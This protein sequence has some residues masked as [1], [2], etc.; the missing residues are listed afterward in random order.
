MR[1]S[2]KTLKAKGRGNATVKATVKLPVR[3]EKTP[4]TGR[5]G[6]SGVNR[7]DL[8][9][10]FIEWSGT[11][12]GERVDDAGNIIPKQK[13]FGEAYHV[14]DQSMSNWKKTPEYKSGLKD[15]NVAWLRPRMGN[16]MK[17]MYARVLKYGMG[18]EMTILLALAYDWE[19][20]QV[21]ESRDKETYTPDDLRAVM[22]KLPTDKKK[23][24]TQLFND[25]LVEAEKYD[26]AH[27]E[28]DDAA[29][30]GE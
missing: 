3:V 28:D 22:N 20:K 25:L 1:K 26:A 13:D 10:K 30:D 2:I 9:R 23:Q 6:K 18:F 4:P 27:S 11:P 19:M 29:H 7:P 12:E 16:A 17:A 21:S 5:G 14:S 24:F 15:A 8:K